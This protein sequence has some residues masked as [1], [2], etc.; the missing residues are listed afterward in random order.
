VSLSRSADFPLKTY[1]GTVAS[2]DSVILDAALEVFDLPRH[3]L[4][5]RYSFTPPLLR[6]L[7]LHD[8]GGLD[9]LF[10]SGSPSP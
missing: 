8:P 7:D 5:I 10:E 9:R 4:R 3:T 6:S 2:S 1:Q